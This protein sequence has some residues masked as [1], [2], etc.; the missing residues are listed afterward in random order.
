VFGYQFPGVTNNWHV[1]F[2]DSNSTTNATNST[3]YIVTNQ[4]ELV[5]VPN[6]N[7]TGPLSVVLYVSDVPN[8]ARYD[9]QTYNFGVGDTII[10]ATA[11]NFV[12]RPLV[13]FTNQLIAMFTN[14]IANSAPGN[15]TATINWG[16]NSLGTGTI[17]TNAAG[18][19]EVRG[20]HTFTNAGNYPVLVSIKSLLGAEAT[21]TSTAIVPPAL[22]LSR[23]GTNSILRWPAFAFDYQ[24]QSNTNLTS[25]NWVA[26]SNLVTLS[27]YDNLSTNSSSGTN[28]FFRLKR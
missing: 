22:T 25:T 12:A 27:G 10:G 26:A 3:F 23:S 11:T 9:Q 15:F 8:F 19:K 24:L 13:Q 20:A 2:A 6:T 16:D 7:Y 1:A 5:V 21:V 4:L 18:F 28:R 14:G 17:Q